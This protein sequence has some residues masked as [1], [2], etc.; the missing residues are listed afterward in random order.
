MNQNDKEMQMHI[1]MNN[2]HTWK[3]TLS[4]TNDTFILTDFDVWDIIVINRHTKSW[5]LLPQAFMTTT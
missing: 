3:Q 1:T 4:I 5:L 2:F